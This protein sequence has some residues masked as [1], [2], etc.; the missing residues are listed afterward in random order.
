MRKRIETKIKAMINH[1]IFLYDREKD[2]RMDRRLTRVEKAT[3]QLQC[4]HSRTAR[5][6][7]FDV[8]PE[9][10]EEICSACGKSFGFYPM[11]EPYQKA[12]KIHAEELSKELS[13]NGN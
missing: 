9:G 2:T 3:K 6:F 1:A 8:S 13:D 7:R 5:C 4:T 10:Y 12:L 11:G